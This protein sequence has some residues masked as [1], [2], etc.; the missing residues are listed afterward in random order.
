MVAEIAE[1]A[2]GT[3]GRAVAARTSPCDFRND[4]AT[5]VRSGAPVFGRH[6][7]GASGADGAAIRSAGGSRRPSPRVR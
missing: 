7:V 5:V 4:G 2:E 6:P 3:R 1:I